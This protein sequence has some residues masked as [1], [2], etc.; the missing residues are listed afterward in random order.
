MR[1]YLIIQPRIE[2]KKKEEKPKKERS[3]CTHSNKDYTQGYLPKSY[4]DIFIYPITSSLE[5]FFFYFVE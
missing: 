4:E 1:I 3:E 2:I 5:L